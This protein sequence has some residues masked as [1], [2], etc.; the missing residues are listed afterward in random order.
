MGHYSLDL[1]SEFLNSSLAFLHGL[2]A[3]GTLSHFLFL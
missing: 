1:T 2:E 3:V